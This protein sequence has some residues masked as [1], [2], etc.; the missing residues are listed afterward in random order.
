[1]TR[2]IDQNFFRIILNVFFFITFFTILL[3]S[4]SLIPVLSLLLYLPFFP[5]PFPSPCVSTLPLSLPPSICQVETHALV[6]TF[7][8][9]TFSS[10]LDVLLSCA[11]FL[12]LTLA[13][14]L[15]PLITA[16]TPPAATLGTAAG[17]ALLEIISLVLSI[18]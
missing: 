1:M 17:A 10:F 6:Q 7:A 15:Y 3:H 13:C 9:P 4:S 16:E 2:E 8:S 5:F 11:V 12:A 18:R 14:F